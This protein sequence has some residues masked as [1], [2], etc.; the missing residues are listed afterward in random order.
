[1]HYRNF[2][3]LKIDFFAILLHQNII[4]FFGVLDATQYTHQLKLNNWNIRYN[5]LAFVAIHK[6]V[7]FFKR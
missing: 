6:S 1:M 4:D 3:V 7:D 5:E 2:F